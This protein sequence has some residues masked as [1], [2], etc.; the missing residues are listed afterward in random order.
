MLTT[1]I[2]PIYH[3]KNGKLLSTVYQP[4]IKPFEETASNFQV[5]TLWFRAWIQLFKKGFD[6]IKLPSEGD[7]VDN[8]I[9]SSIQV[10]RNEI[11]KM[12]G[13]LENDLLFTTSTFQDPRYKQKIFSDIG[14]D[15]V[16]SG[17]LE[18]KFGDI[19]LYEI[20]A[21]LLEFLKEKKPLSIK[22]L[23]IGGKQN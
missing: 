18:V 11:N 16:K 3:P 6:D 1:I 12:F 7:T 23:L 20:K 8:T 15:K 2:F 4:F 17:S 13:Y 9:I 19:R 10:I 21:Q 5:H 14:K 22:T